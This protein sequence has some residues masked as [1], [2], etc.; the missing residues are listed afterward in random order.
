MV[1]I[2]PSPPFTPPA[3]WRTPPI[4]MNARSVRNHTASSNSGR[5]KGWTQV[6]MS[7]RVD[8]VCACGCPVSSSPTRFTTLSSR[9]SLTDDD[10]RKPGMQIGPVV[11]ETQSRGTRARSVRGLER[12]VVVGVTR[13]VVV[14]HAG[15][16][17]ARHRDRRGAGSAAAATTRRRDR[18]RQPGRR[19]HPEPVIALFDAEAGKLEC[20]VRRLTVAFSNSSVGTKTRSSLLEVEGEALPLTLLRGSP[21]V[22]SGWLR[23]MI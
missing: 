19:R 18:D 8:V 5:G 7:R 2:P 11:G 9:H 1:R 17:A 16:G 21:R 14:H 23:R 12:G 22:P 15:G 13:L 10:A 6:C 3:S 20:A 4:Y